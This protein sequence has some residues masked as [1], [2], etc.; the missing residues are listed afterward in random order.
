MLNVL[1]SITVFGGHRTDYGSYQLSVDG[2]VVASGSSAGQNTVLQ[3]LGT[4]SELSNGQ[5]TAILSSSSA[6]PIDIDYVSIEAE[7][8]SPG[9]VLDD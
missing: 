9:F 8:G 1:F 6:S 7:I 3:S 2:N 4:A 5:H